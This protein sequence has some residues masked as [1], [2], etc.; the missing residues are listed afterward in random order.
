L[1][2][3]EKDSSPADTV[4]THKVKCS[5][6]NIITSFVLSVRRDALNMQPNMKTPHAKDNKRPAN[7]N[8]LIQLR[9]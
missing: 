8:L 3:K 9:I 2:D 4:D 5:N 7:T 6:P 1:T